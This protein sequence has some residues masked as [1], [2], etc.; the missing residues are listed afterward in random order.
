MSNS[1][2]YAVSP[3]A[4]A[5]VSAEFGRLI[6]DVVYLPPEA[7]KLIKSSPASLQKWRCEGGGPTFIKIGRRRVGY[8]GAAL[9]SWLAN[10]AAT[11]CADARA[12]GLS[13]AS[14]SALQSA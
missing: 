1:G 6:D 10:R 14:T 4:I 5:A 3:K 11:S 8:T 9:K 13:A 7:A 2:P 12:R